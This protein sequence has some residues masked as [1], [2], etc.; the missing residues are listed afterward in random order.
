MLLFKDY[1]HIAGLYLGK[2]YW[3]ILRFNNFLVVVSQLINTSKG[4]I[5]ISS[6]SIWSYLKISTSQNFSSLHICCLPFLPE[7]SAYYNYFKFPDS[8]NI[9]VRSKPDR[10]I[11][12]SLDYVLF[13]PF[14]FLYHIIF[15]L[16]VSILCRKV[17][18]EIRNI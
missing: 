17:E 5:F 15:V 13:P 6:I 10:V 11:V 8:S 1:W 4:F 16:K 2:F 18:T 14:F 3:S 12:L 9:Y 7:P